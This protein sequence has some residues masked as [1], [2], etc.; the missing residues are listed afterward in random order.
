M[1]LDTIGWSG[2]KSTLDCLAMNPAIV[3]LPGSFMRG[4]HAAAILRRIGCEE[5]VAETIDEYIAI[6]ARLGLDAAYRLRL[7]RAVAGSKHLAFRDTSYIRALEA[8]LT[9]AVERS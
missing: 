6:A 8:F 4:R 7:R 9:A 1:I 5:T 2:G 3:T